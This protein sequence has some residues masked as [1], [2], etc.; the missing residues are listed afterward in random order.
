MII[1]FVYLFWFSA[2][3]AARYV[4][5]DII[6]LEKLDELGE[7]DLR[8]AVF[9][10]GRSMKCLTTDAEEPPVARGGQMQKPLRGR[11][12]GASK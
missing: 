6:E 2:L 7:E 3:K 8:E 1:C 5:A 4:D 11:W 12:W 9:G 10:V